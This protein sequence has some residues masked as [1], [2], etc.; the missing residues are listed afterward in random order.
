MRDL[1]VAFPNAVQALRGVSLDVQRG[2]IVA[3][4]GESGSGKTILGLAL[5]GLCPVDAKLSGEV[6]LGET[7]M[8]AADDE[9]RRL[10][11]RAAAG[12]VFQ[13]PMTSLNP[14][15]RVGRQ[16]AE[17]AGS[18][19]LATDLLRRAGIREAPER[20]RQFPHQ[21]SGGLRQR[22]MIAM[23]IARNPALLVLDEPTT[24][25]DVTIQLEI[26]GLFRK[27]REE[28]GVAM[29]FITHDLA[30]AHSIADRIVVL[31]AGRL[32]EVG[33]AA[34]LVTRPS[35]PYTAG[36]LASRIAID[37]RQPLLLSLPGEP[38][39][40]RQPPAGCPFSPRCGFRATRCDSVV[41]R[42]K[43]SSR[44]NGLDAC[45][46][47]SELPELR[48]LSHSSTEGPPQRHQE[49]NRSSKAV[50]SGRRGRQERLD[51][52]AVI[53]EGVT[54]SFG[55]RRGR[56]LVLNDVSLR[57]PC[58]GAVA[59][60][61]ESGCGKTTLLRMIVGLDRPDG[62]EIRLAEGARP[63]LVFQEAGAS[64][65]P[66]LTVRKLLSERLAK[67]PAAIRD[68]RI[69][70]VLTR[71]GLAPDIADRR[72]LEL[73]GG[74]RQRVAIARAVVEPPV[75]LACDEPTSALDVSLAA[76]VLNLLRELRA[77][78]DMALLFVT[79]D[80][81]IASAIADSIIVISD[82]VV[83]EDG[84]AQQ[85]LSAPA[86]EYTRRLVEAAPTIG[87]AWQ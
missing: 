24:A 19:T 39:D 81:F 78:L 83:V 17:A 59:L 21:L 73:S 10:A 2:E 80:L 28:L 70:D 42:L 57:V 4:V 16:V 62:G 75:L 56:R 8:V 82:G 64:L 53:V 1:K 84:P 23:A 79:H 41:P 15:M 35:H 71:V 45:I 12:A 63:Q 5:L 37:S 22:V 27:L 43:P 72:P 31:Y 49:V 26:L 9:Q 30:V 87:A 69:N 55:H 60:V 18:Q 34:E 67:A 36:L 46:R 32:A 66:W 13:D 58:G 52:D 76:T 86:A 20:L 44:H 14:T 77:E 7:E 29:V 65:T 74:Q 33:A 25:L 11:R 85:V 54:K 38:P 51:S 48:S 68:R 50:R 3:V 61:G 40:P 6:W 47:S